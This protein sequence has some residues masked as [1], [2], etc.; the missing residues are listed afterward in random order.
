VGLSI[1]GGG[2]RSATFALGVV[3]VLARKGILRQIDYLSTVS[4]GGYLGAFIS[5]FLNDASRRV[6]LKENDGELPFG[7]DGNGESQSVRHLRNH[8]KY[9]SEGGF[10]TFATMVALVAY[11]VLVSV[12]LLSPFLFT[13]V[14]IAQW[15]F[16]K[17][18]TPPPVPFLPLS[19]VTGISLAVLAVG[20]AVLPVA[21]KFGRG[22]RLQKSWETG[23][24]VASVVSVLL[25]TCE[26]FPQVFQ[27]VERAGGASIALGF[28]LLFP[29]VC[30]GLGLWLGTSIIGR[31]LLRLLQIAGPLLIVS[32][33]FWLCEFF[34]AK[35]EHP[36]LSILASTTALLW[37][38][39]TFVLNI[40][41]A[42]P[43]RFYRNRLARTYLT[44]PDGGGVQSCDPQ[45]LSSINAQNKA[46]Y[47]LINAA[48]NIPSCKEPNLRGRNT[49]FFLFSK[50]Y[51]GSPIVGFHETTKWEEMDPHLD[52]GTAMAISGAAAA[53]H[54]GTLTASRYTFLLAMLNVRLGYWLRRPQSGRGKAFKRLF[55]PIGWLYFFRELT[56]LMSERTS[57]LNVSD[58]GH[59][60]NLGIYELLRRRCK[61]VIAIDGEADPKRSF[62]GLLSL[63][64]LA[65][66]DLG[67]TIEPDLTELR[68]GPE[69]HGRAHFGL[70]RIDYP[71]GDHG[72][73]L[74]IKSSLTGNES[75]FLKKYR[76]ENP[77]FPHQS[78]AQQLFS[79]TQFEAYRALGEHVASDLF[80]SDLL[81]N[82]QEKPSV[83]GWFKSLATHLL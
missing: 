82:W 66:I 71:G 11:G 13:G 54:M 20:V 28:A 34:I 80:R 5:S 76:S 9:L 69:G 62:G 42:S 35:P 75:E 63:T 8:S 68:M 29:F 16:S 41:F 57:Y 1:S 3:Q 65:K 67:V 47:H 74:Y 22:G 18:F 60:E 53:P 61:F 70:S 4:G 27:A 58:G 46:P 40:N 12:L 77:D 14:V 21:Q 15:L 59:I 6:S 30:G 43:H 2:I 45:P 25:L 44:R 73:L 7:A 64:Q 31:T 55:P 24:I 72:L 37:F 32:A 23:C 51:C 49:D 10:K 78:T 79:E 39:T 33:L 48:L 81:D 19:T 17:S 38:Y 56:G 26:E 36:S 52:L 50:H 83:Q